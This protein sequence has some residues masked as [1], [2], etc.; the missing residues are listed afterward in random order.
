MYGIV[1]KA[2]EGLVITKFGS[3][4]WAEIKLKSGVTEDAFL[5]NQSYPDK[6]TFDLAISASEVLKIDLKDILIEFGE[7]W[8]LNTGQENYGSLMKAGGN[9]LKEFLINLPNFH[10][11]VM[12][13]YPKLTPPEFKITNIESNAVQ[14]HYYS[15]RNGLTYFM[16]G[17]LSGLGKMYKVDV[18]INILSEKENNGDHDVFKISWN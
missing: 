17:L 12:L 10:S 5:S 15:T 7:Y 6:T 9:N 3:E 18:E 14:V 1:N 16:Y 11:R 8:V 4:K 13:I 2:I